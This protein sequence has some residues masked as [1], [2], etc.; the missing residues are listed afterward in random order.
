VA[1]FIGTDHHEMLITN[2]GF[3]EEDLRRV[4]RHVGSRFPIRPRF[5]RITSA[6]RFARTFKVCLSGDGGDEVFAGYPLFQWLACESTEVAARLAGADRSSGRAIVPVNRLNA[7][8]PDQWPQLRRVWRGPRSRG[9]SGALAPFARV[10]A[11]PGRRTA[12]SA[13]AG[14]FATTPRTATALN[15][16]SFVGISRG[17]VR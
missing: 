8:W 15:P 6:A 5:P 9:R 3:E 11:V 12:D 7:P 17:C 14:L 13:E 1:Q 4:V 2:G 10:K 16:R